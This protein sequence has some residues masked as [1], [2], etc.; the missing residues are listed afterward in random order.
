MDSDNDSAGSRKISGIYTGFNANFQSN[1]KRRTKIKS[2]AGDRGGFMQ[3]RKKNCIRFIQNV[4][5]LLSRRL[6]GERLTTIVLRGFA[7]LVKH[8][9]RAFHLTSFARVSGSP[10]NITGGSLIY[11]VF[12]T[13]SGIW[14][15][16][17]IISGF[18]QEV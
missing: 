9:T 13:I 3:P 10:V 18:A 5:S 16:I 4:L 11:I 14:T 8:L 2:S 7:E 6:R 17:I 15:P 1:E 12:S